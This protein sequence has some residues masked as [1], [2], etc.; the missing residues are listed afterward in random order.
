MPNIVA[1]LMKKRLK[2]T[3]VHRSNGCLL[4]FWWNGGCGFERGAYTGYANSGRFIDSASG[5]VRP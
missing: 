3:D 1:M 4:R 2:A 5:R